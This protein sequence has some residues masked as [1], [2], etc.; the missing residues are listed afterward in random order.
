MASN[1]FAIHKHSENLN[2]YFIEGESIV[3]YKNIDDL[4]N[5]I[6]YYMENYNKALVI[7]ENSY[8]IVKKLDLFFDKKLKIILE[9]IK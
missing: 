9:G 5:K 7:R 3:T 6:K 2:K 4:L 8:N 1:I